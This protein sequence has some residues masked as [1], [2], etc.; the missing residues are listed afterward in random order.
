MENGGP[1]SSEDAEALTATLVEE[2]IERWRYGKRPLPEEFLERHPDLWNH[3]EAAT[4]LIYEEICLRQEYGQMIPEEEVLSRFPQ[5]RR[6]LEVLFDCQRLLGPGS[7]APLFPRVGG[8]LGDFLLLAELGDGVHGRVFLASQASL[9]GRPVV[10][11]LIPLEACEHLSLARLQHTHIVPVFSVQDHPDRGL[12][13]MCMPYFGGATLSQVFDSLRSRPVSQRSG[14]DLLDALIHAPDSH[15]QPSCG[16]QGGERELVMPAS[17]ALVKATYV[18]AMCWIGACLAE[19][20]Q[21][22]HE[23]GLIHLDLKPSNVLLTADGQPMVLDFHLA[24]G[25]IRHGPRSS[26][27]NDLPNQPE[28]EWPK[29]RR[30]TVERLEDRTVPSSSAAW[31]LMSSLHHHHHELASSATASTSTQDSSTQGSSTS[32]NCDQSNS[33]QSSTSGSTSTGDSSTQSSTS[34]S[35]ST[36]DSTTQ[37][38]STGGQCSKDNS[39]TSTQ[40]SATQDTAATSSDTSQ[41]GSSQSSS[42]GSNCSQ[43]SQSTSSS[44]QDSSTASASTT[45]PSTTT[46]SSSTSTAT[47]TPSSAASASTATQDTAASSSSTS[48]SVIL[49]SSL[50]ANSSDTTQNSST[51]SGSSS[52]TATG[53]RPIDEV[54]NNVANPTWGT[55]N[56]DL[57]RVSPA[58]YADGISSP[59]LPNDPSARAISNIVN[60]QADPNNP[61]QDVN[62]VDSNNLSDFGYVWGQFIDHD[63]DLTPTNSGESFPISVAAGDP[64][65]TQ[66][67]ERSSFDPTT[68]TST[69]NPRQQTNVDTSFLDLSQVYGSSATVADALRTHSGGHLKTS[70]GDML[71]LNNTSFFTVDQLAALNMANDSQAAPSSSLVAA[72]DV[73]ANENVEL[74]ALQTLFVRNHN[75]LAAELQQE[76]PDWTDE[77]LYQEARKLNIAQGQMITYNEY[78]PDLLGPTALSKY[79][80]YNPNVDPA[81][82]TEFSTVAFRFGHSLLSDEI[83]RANNNGLDITDVSADGASIPL[84]QDFFDPNL[85]NATGAVDPL[86]GHT[87]SDIGAVLKGDADGV[88]NA[89]DT[90]VIS[91]VRNLLFG[92]G[93][94]GGQD[95]IARDIQRARD[96]GIGTYNQVREAYGLAPVTSFAQITSNVTV[97]NELKQAYGTVDN[98]DPFEGGLAEDHVK[99][100]DVGPL[101][102]SIMVDQFT[103]LR[104][105]DRFFYLNESF[106]PDEMKLLNQGNTLTKVIEANTNIT[107]L[108]SDVMEFKASISGT[109]L[110]A[111]TTNGHAAS[112]GG[113]G[114]GQRNGAQHGLGGIT[115]ELMDDSGNV[116]GTTTT[117]SRG[118]YTFNQQTGIGGTG[119]YTVAL[120]LP[121]GDNQTSKSPST[122]LI[123]RGDVNVR[124]VNFTVATSTQ[125]TPTTGHHTST[126]TAA[127]S[128]SQTVDTSVMDAL[129]AEMGS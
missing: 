17:R 103:R 5:W 116:V 49:A 69:S 24:R 102:Q 115:V 19:A 129:F 63:M 120:V 15:V 97:Q 55:A 91:A 107:N 4:D 6:Q 84:A 26:S 14:Q 96:D 112:L 119:N 82:A 75:R 32:H 66:P 28:L 18:E 23:R 56:T 68:G 11:K 73:R 101:F 13:S 118:H 22:A 25:P 121:T 124:G 1:L 123:S 77:Q 125:S 78:L 35:T 48:P 67:F 50:V 72:G 85:L 126:Q 106:T 31:S 38:S 87:A 10:L 99:G 46:Q 27:N 71:P 40:S 113:G 89:M 60:N 42:S 33:S 81:I 128:T 51:Q 58:A 61:S 62:T 2:M 117:D 80:G 34:G 30:L 93:A 12:R 29:P 53:F 88:A 20:L 36:G 92:N 39:S 70:S 44:T 65:G 59:S 57:L 8:S 47:A 127:A 52:S 43:N 109:V 100:S 74:T 21:Y 94:Q 111:S 122:I 3:P 76:H 45:T 41:T 83:E 37:S 114:H 86:T 90:Q 98:I 108:Q 54:G 79:T 104:D 64:I 7:V 16:H 9:G 110:S 95:L 105:G